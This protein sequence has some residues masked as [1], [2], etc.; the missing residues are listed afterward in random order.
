MAEEPTSTRSRLASM[1]FAKTDKTFQDMLNGVG[2]SVALIQASRPQIPDSENVQRASDVSLLAKAKGMGAFVLEGHKMEVATRQLF[3]LVVGDEQQIHSFAR[4]VIRE[5]DA[6]SDWFLFWRPGD[7]LVQENVDRS[8]NA[9]VF[10]TDGLT[11][12]DGGEFKFERTYSPDQFST[13]WG[14]STEAEV[15]DLLKAV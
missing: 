10:N 3:V 4:K 2:S 11:L 14:H 9:C 8:Q 6:A 5:T 13:I 15:G 1:L 7:D 12:S